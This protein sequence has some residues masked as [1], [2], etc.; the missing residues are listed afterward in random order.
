[1]ILS[2]FRSGNV[3]GIALILGNDFTNITLVYGIIC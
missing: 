3:F 2:I 1:L